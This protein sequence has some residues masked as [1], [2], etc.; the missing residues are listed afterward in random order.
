VAATAAIA[1]A[2]CKTFLRSIV[3]RSLQGGNNNT[4]QFVS[5]RICFHGAVSILAFGSL[6][7]LSKIITYNER[8]TVAWTTARSS[9]RSVAPIGIRDKEIS[10]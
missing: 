10:W 9:L 3:Q 1:P 7:F 2:P 4:G 6:H 5:A 8:T